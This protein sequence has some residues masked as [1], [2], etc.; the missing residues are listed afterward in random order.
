MP[1]IGR[2]AHADLDSCIVHLMLRTARFRFMASAW[3]MGFAALNGKG[4]IASRSQ[5]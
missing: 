2:N 5:G 4:F 1:E 3:R